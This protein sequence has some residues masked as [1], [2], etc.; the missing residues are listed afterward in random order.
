MLVGE[1]FQLE[2]RNLK[3]E[4]PLCLPWPNASVHPTVKKAR[5]RCNEFL[6]LLG[7]RYVATLVE[8]DQMRSGDSRR[9]ALAGRERNQGVF[10]SPDDQ[11]RRLD[12][13]ELSVQPLLAQ[14]GIRQKAMHGIA[15]IPPNDLG[16]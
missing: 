14:Y 15:V 16:K 3:L 10:A 13:S 5:Y 9:I 12:L 2:T 1:T 11:R 4:T 7:R 8:G 6:G